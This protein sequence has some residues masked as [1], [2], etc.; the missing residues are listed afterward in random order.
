MR[1]QLIECRRGK[2]FAVERNKQLPHVF[3]PFAKSAPV[4]AR[5]NFVPAAPRFDMEIT[6]R[7]E[8]LDSRDLVAGS[9]I[10]TGDLSLDDDRGSDLIGYKAVRRLPESR[11]PL[12]LPGWADGDPGIP[13]SV[14]DG[15]LYFPSYHL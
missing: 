7:H 12:R 4:D 2:Y 14:F 13:E 15:H 11:N 3:P 9:P 1:D 10:V 5:D 8:V 6:L